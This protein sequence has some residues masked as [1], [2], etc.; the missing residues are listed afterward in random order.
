MVFRP[1]EREIFKRYP[2]L[3]KIKKDTGFVP[4]ISLDEGIKNLLKK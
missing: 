1:K 2:D 3:K 4:R